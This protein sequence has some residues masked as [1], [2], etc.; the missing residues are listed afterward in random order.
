MT[1]PKIGQ[2]VKLVGEQIDPDM[3]GT[4]CRIV[5]VYDRIDVWWDTPTGEDKV[6]LM[7]ALE[8]YGAEKAAT[9]TWYAEVVSTVDEGMGQAV[10]SFECEEVT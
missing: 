9:A 10:A 2:L 4:V 3:L 6:A 7:D 1:K 5:A 8:I